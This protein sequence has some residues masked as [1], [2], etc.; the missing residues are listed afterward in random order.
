MSTTTIRIFLVHGDPNR[1][2]TAE[3]SN[4]TGKAGAPDV[5]EWIAKPEI[6]VLAGK[7][8]P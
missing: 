8:N 1:L 4:W 6:I 3:L 5:A 2:R 7:N